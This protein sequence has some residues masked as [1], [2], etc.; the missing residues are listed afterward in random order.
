MSLPSNLPDSYKHVLLSDR[1]A[2][3]LADDHLS[4]R[5]RMVGHPL[6]PFLTAPQLTNA[7]DGHGSPLETAPNT[8]LQASLVLNAPTPALNLGRAVDLSAR[9]IDSYL[10]TCKYSTAPTDLA[11][12]RLH[13]VFLPHTLD[14]SHMLLSAYSLARRWLLEKVHALTDIPLRV[15]NILGRELAHR[16]R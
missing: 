1:P 7:A 11:I 10:L 14:S 5:T 12:F 13:G 8:G 3:V 16:A 2:P 4:P 15:R 6:A 9:I